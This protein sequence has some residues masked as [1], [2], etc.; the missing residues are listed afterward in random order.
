M[1]CPTWVKCGVRYLYKLF[2][3]TCQ[4]HENWRREGR[5]FLWHKWNFM[6]VCTVKPYDSPPLKKNIQNASVQ[7][8]YCNLFPDFFHADFTVLLDS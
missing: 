4:F 2:F 5:A 1:Y 7:S 3:G 8:V 6:Y